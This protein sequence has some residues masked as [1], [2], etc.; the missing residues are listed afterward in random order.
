MFKMFKRSQ[1]ET[2]QP[3]EPQAPAPTPEDPAASQS[4]NPTVEPTRAEP[5]F[6]GGTFPSGDV[7]PVSSTPSPAG[8]TP[9]PGEVPLPGATPPPEPQPAAPL[10]PPLPP[11]K[12]K[13]S[14]LYH[15]FSP[16]TRVGRVTRPVLRWLAAITG[17]FALGLLAGYLVL[18][19]PTQR[20]LDSALAQLDQ[21]SQAASQQNKSQQVALSDRNQAQAAYEKA[22]ADL[23]KAASENKLLVE[24]VDVSNARVALVNKDGAAAKIAIQQAQTDFSS[25]LPYLQSQDKTRADVLQSRLDLVAK[26]L[27][28]DPQATLADLDKL[29][30][31][32]TD[33]H[34]KLFP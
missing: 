7:A 28:S 20:S 10:Y 8:E 1:P 34:K 21:A 30:A 15:L 31:D 22:Q 27:V 2:I 26:E 14:L 12:D 33:L 3:S 16:E 9:A 19:Q 29:S 25:V 4:N 6:P 5:A 11:R 24:L 18:Y 13:K 17:L 32:L 23:A